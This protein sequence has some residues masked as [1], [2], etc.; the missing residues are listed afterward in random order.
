MFYFDQSVVHNTEAYHGVERQTH[1]YRP[2]D[3]LPGPPT[4][5]ATSKPDIEYFQ[6]SLVDYTKAQS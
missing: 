3:I 1:H 5:E 2:K 4:H 6:N